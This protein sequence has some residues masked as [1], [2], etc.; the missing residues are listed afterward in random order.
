MYP[1]GI[2]LPIETSGDGAVNVY[3]RVQMQMF[4]ARQAAKKE[5]DVALEKTGQTMEEVQAW[6]AKY[7]KLGRAFHRSPH[8]VG[9]GTADLVYE[10]ARHRERRQRPLR[11]AYR[12][13]R[14]RL[15]KLRRRGPKQSELVA[16]ALRASKKAKPLGPQSGLA[17]K[18]KP[19]RPQPDSSDA[20]K[21]LPV[22]SR[23]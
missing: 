20:P 9:C 12:G 3:S 19:I 16:T 7:P 23:G 8:V 15:G 21:P 11:T 5:V 14:R 22:V 4:K 18:A 10:V 6:I 13:L 17:D 2:F 1:Q